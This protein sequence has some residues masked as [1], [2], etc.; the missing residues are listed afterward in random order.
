MA[1][2]STSMSGNSGASGNAS[3]AIADT[4]SQIAGIAGKQIDRMVEGA[5]HTLTSVADTG[6]DATDR[7]QEVAG[8]VKSAVDKSLRDQP[9]AT[10]AVAAGLGFVI[11]A[12]WKS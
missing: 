2:T 1:S 6:R 5:Q 3:A 9:M 4:A 8:N 7:V 12:L 10:L 11:G